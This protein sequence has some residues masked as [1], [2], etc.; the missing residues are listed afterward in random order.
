LA[1]SSSTWDLAELGLDGVR[2]LV[3]MLVGTAAPEIGI[4]TTSSAK[5]FRRLQASIALR[6]L[7]SSGD[8]RWRWPHRCPGKR[9]FIGASRAGQDAEFLARRAN[10]SVSR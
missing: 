1:S 7:R 5:R 8:Q 9:R 6:G 10:K 2:Y 3:A 4:A